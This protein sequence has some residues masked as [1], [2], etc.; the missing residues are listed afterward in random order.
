MRGAKPLGETEDPPEKSGGRLP[1]TARHEIMREKLLEKAAELFGAQGFARTSINEIADALALKRSSLYY[2]FP[3]KEA[4][5]RELFRGEFER[6]IAELEA[7][8]ER[9]DLSATERLVAAVEGAIT[10]RLRGR[11]R[12]LVFDRIEPEL[13]EDLRHV[14]NLARRRILDLYVAMIELGIARHEFRDVDPQMTTFALIGM[15]N[16]TALWYSPV[17]RMTP[18]ELARHFTE[19]LIF[20]ISR[21]ARDALQQSHLD[22]VR[23]ALES[24]L[25]KLDRLGR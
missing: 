4:F 5:L 12:F 25:A 16:W 9:A 6:R 1:S 19:L 2:Y 13:P 14:Y 17:G 7:L 11:G 22:E 20:G 24:G 18:P 21:S 3:N 15:S 10:Q 23:A 8:L